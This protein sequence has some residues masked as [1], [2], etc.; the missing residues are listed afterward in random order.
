MPPK[1]KMHAPTPD[2]QT[3]F[4]RCRVLYCDIK[5]II[6]HDEL[7]ITCRDANWDEFKLLAILRH[8]ELFNHRRIFIR[9]RGFMEEING[10]TWTGHKY[11]QRNSLG[12]D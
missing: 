6:P 11:E 10:W 7:Y 2:G 5:G 12:Q 8:P 9:D 4:E 1:R 3:Y